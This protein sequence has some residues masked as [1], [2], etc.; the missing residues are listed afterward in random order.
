MCHELQEFGEVG[1]G[2]FELAVELVDMVVDFLC[3]FVVESDFSLAEH[4]FANHAKCD[5]LAVENRVFVVAHGESLECM[6]ECVAEV[7][8]L[9]DTLFFG[10]FCYEVV[11]DDY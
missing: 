6:A 4:E 9:A 7:E 1:F 8:S 2:K 3:V 5:G 10:V 11:F